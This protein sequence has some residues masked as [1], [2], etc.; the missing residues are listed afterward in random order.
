MY[1]FN[2]IYNTAVAIERKGIDF[3]EKLKD[4][5]N[6]AIVDSII[7]DEKHHIEKFNEFFENL[8]K[9]TKEEDL[10]HFYMDE[11]MMVEA[12]SSTEVFGKLNAGKMKKQE[13]YDVAIMIEKDSILFYS[14]LKDMLGGDIKADIELELLKSLIKEEG[15]HLGKFIELKNRMGNPT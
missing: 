3:Y 13:L 8:R 12:F 15:K 6:N 4:G 5:T 9:K 11:D 14:Q 7:E 1:S 10:P 2:V